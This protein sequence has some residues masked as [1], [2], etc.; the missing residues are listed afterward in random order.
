MIAEPPDTYGLW[1]A[2]KAAAPPAWPD[3]DEDR[4]GSLAATW[5]ASSLPF[6][7]MSQTDTGGLR[8]AW[9]DAAGYA[10]AG[11]LDMLKSR[12]AITASEMDGMSAKT[13][14]F[15][16]LV[17]EIKNGIVELIEMNLESYGY[18]MNL[19]D[20]VR[21]EVQSWFVSDIAA[22]VRELMNT[23]VAAWLPP[24]TNPDGLE[25]LGVYVDGAVARTQD[26][27]RGDIKE[28]YDL[29][30]LD[31]ALTV[32]EAAKMQGAATLAGE[33]ED[34][35][36]QARMTDDL[37]NSPFGATLSEEARTQLRTQ[38]D[39]L[40][41]RAL[42]S[43]A[44]AGVLATEAGWVGRAAPY[45]GGVLG[46]A[47]D[48]AWT[49]KSW[50]QIAAGTAASAA[51]GYAGSTLG[52]GAT[53][54]LAAAAFGATAGSAVPIVGTIVGG[55]VGMGFGLFASGVVDGLWHGDSLA[56]AFHDGGQALA[57]AGTAIADGADWVGDRFLDGAVIATGAVSEFFDSIF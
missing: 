20:G 47:W 35:F 10:Y 3:T 56:E 19:P 6:T 33:S 52:A 51:A 25:G 28:K 40:R 11:R 29:L 55:L 17:E 23:D 54:W 31:G 21:E 22:G 15:R 39:D 38:A 5:K 53:T 8:P 48:A 44:N 46:A 1:G 13:Y 24:D 36:R 34:L 16:T 49:D 9:D 57:D 2:V 41:L 37:L 14:R 18:T 30:V 7:G 4:M 32:A 26:A 45:V 12:A 43:G 50:A 42:N 27:I